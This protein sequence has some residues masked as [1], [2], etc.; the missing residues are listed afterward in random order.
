[1]GFFARLK[2]GW[3]LAK[4]S[5]TVLRK[6][7]ELM[8]FPLISGVAGLLF[9][10]LLFGGSY[11]IGAFESQAL[12]IAV[13]FVFYLGTSFLAA[14]FNGG[15][16][17]SARNAFEG[18]DPSVKRGL[19][20]AWTHVRPLLAYAI[21]SAIVGLLLRA[22]E[23][24]DNL[25]AQVAAIF[26]SVAW[27][28]VTYFIIPVI[29]FEDVGVREMFE[30]SGETFKNTWGETAGANFG[31]GLFSFAV[32][33]VGLLIAA[34]IMLLFTSSAGTGGFVVGAVIAGTMLLGIFL[35]VSALGVVAKTALYVYAT[36]GERPSE[37]RN[38]DFE[39]VGR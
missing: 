34:A 7:P 25:A 33:A 39:R 9:I 23:N 17:Y 26:V 3:R 24:Q 12:G 11:V 16:V 32:M 27:S 38:V 2:T 20:E 30:R 5:F 4:D 37:F 6:Q 31:I 36:T 10:A 15:L 22:I 28:V 18:R 8:V 14:F 21:I 1:M 19:R 13:L 35:F 29:I